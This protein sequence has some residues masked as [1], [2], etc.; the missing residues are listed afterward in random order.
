MPRSSSPGQ[1]TRSVAPHS[2]YRPYILGSFWRVQTRLGVPRL[3]S[4]GSGAG[5]RPGRTERSGIKSPGVSR[6]TTYPVAS[7]LSARRAA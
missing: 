2:P 4:S 6:F 7:G 3:S 1:L 5:E